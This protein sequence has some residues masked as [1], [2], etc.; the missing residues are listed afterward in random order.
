MRAG[1]IELMPRVAEEVTEETVAR[2]RALG[3][4]GT[5]WTLQHPL[6]VDEAGLRHVRDVLAGGGIR[7]AQAVPRN[8][9]LVAADPERRRQGVREL[10]HAC[11]AA[12]VLHAATLYVRPGSVNP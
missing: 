4:T 5:H 12:R 1:V 11:R 6:D 3:F 2:L 7:V 8:Q 9:D 10:Q